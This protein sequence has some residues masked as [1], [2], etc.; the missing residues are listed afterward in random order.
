MSSD[1]PASTLTLSRFFF[2]F[3][4]A[5]GLY[6]GDK[7]GRKEN[8]FSLASR[9]R[10]SCS[11]PEKLGGMTRRCVLRG[12]Q[13]TRDVDAVADVLNG[14]MLPLLEDAGTGLDLDGVCVRAVAAACFFGIDAQSSSS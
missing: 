6:S 2:C 8:F 1:A 7:A 5:G 9:T 10:G 13:C 11:A 4:G 14:V 12:V 3:G